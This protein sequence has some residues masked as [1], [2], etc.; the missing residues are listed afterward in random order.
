MRSRIFRFLYIL[1]IH[2]LLRFRKRNTVTVFCFHRISPERDFFFDPVHPHRFA[3]FLRY[4]KKYYHI[5]TFENIHQSSDKPKA[6]IS[7]DD[8]YKDFMEHA[9]PALQQA[10]LPANHNLVNVCLSNGHLIWT[11]KL[12][13]VFTYFKKNNVQEEEILNKLGI[14]FKTSQSNWSAYSLRVFR[15]LVKLP[16][17]ER[18]Q[19]INEL[20]DRYAK[21]NTV[22]MMDWED[23]RLC[24]KHNIEIGSHTY[25]HE[26]LDTLSA[27]ELTDEIA[28]SVH[29]LS[30][31]LNTKINVL[32]LPNGFYNQW[33][34][35]SCEEAGIKYV[36]AVGDKL[37]SSDDLAGDFNVC[38]RINMLNE[39]VPEMIFRGE[40]FHSVVRSYGFL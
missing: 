14:T 36:L 13:F 2:H 24:A 27:E 39:A 17:H 26:V 34:L 9:L 6:V 35:K 1:G 8:G 15:Y 31:K 30:A 7:F 3:D 28:K 12:N 29:E 40:L 5:T 4:A 33:V 11:Q 37:T 23:A 19:I 21:T 10:G 32:A 18:N 25:S 22:P 16:A 38:H 20:F